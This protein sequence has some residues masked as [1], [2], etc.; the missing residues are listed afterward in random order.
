ML[1]FSFGDV[2]LIT[3]ILERLGV[4]FVI[5]IELLSSLVLLD[6]VD[7][8]GDIGFGWWNNEIFLLG[9]L[10]RTE[11]FR[12]EFGFFFIDDDVF[13]VLFWFIFKFIKIYYKI[14]FKL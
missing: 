7:V 10:R 3:G 8:E 5:I 11:K 13:L 12:G 14:I 1:L 4:W 9:L 6:E 2:R